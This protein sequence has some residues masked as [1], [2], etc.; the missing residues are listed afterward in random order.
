M[1]DAPA[2]KL[3]GDKLLVELAKYTAKA[4]RILLN[5]G[6]SPQEKDEARTA[7]GLLNHAQGLVGVEDRSARRLLS[8]AKR[9]L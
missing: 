6:S 3:T 7:L 8:I 2:Q 9:A 1:S 4:G 5:K